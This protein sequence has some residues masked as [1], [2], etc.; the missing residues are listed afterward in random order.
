MAS[1]L[2]LATATNQITYA[3][4]A[5][6]LSDSLYNLCY[7]VQIAARRPDALWRFRHIFQ[8]NFLVEGKSRNCTHA[9]HLTNIWVLKGIA[10]QRIVPRLTA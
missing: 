7:P 9:V 4:G 6:I 2:G 5:L 3:Y 10:C 8:P 1:S